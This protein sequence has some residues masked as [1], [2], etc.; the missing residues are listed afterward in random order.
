MPQS[1]LSRK[2]TT[3]D[4]RVPPQ[5]IE[6]EQSVLGGLLVDARRW[7]EVAEAVATE[8]FY[9]RSHRE[10]FT[11]LRSLNENGVAVDLVTPAVWLKNKGTPKKTGGRGL[12]LNP[13]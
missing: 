10:I 12:P 5:A 6:A 2:P 9:T 4:A 11:A 7:D 8:D 13:L 3:L 1:E